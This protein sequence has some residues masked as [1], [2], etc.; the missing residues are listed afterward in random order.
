MNERAHKMPIRIFSSFSMCKD[1]NNSKLNV[2]I[3][4]DD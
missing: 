2:L 3:M 1:T 4:E